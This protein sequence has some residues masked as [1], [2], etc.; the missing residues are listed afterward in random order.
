VPIIKVKKPSSRKLVKSKTSE[1]S[2]NIAQLIDMIFKLALSVQVLE[3]KSQP[4]PPQVFK[5]GISCS[6]IAKSTKKG[7]V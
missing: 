6:V 1:A 5:L 3:G 4:S 7:I 2:A